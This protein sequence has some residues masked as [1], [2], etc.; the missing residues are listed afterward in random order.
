MFIYILNDIELSHATVRSLC[1]FVWLVVFQ[2]LQEFLKDLNQWE[3]RVKEKDKELKAK[4]R[5]GVLVRVTHCSLISGILQ[6]YVAKLFDVPDCSRILS[7]SINC[8]CT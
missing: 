7:Y 1:V 4:P 5:E 8:C 3:T 2:E 6:V